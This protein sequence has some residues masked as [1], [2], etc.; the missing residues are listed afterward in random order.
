MN[1]PGFILAGGASSRYGSPKALAPVGGVRVVDRVA[2][3]LRA[4]LHGAAAGAAEVYAIVN[5]ADLAVE[6]GLPHRADVIRGVGP[7]AGIHAALHWARELGGVG[8]LAAGCDMPF[9]EPALLG[10]LVGRSV[11]RDVVIP[12]SDGPR[13]VEPLC[14]FYGT[15][16][17]PAIEAA[18]ER[19]DA[20]MIGFHA[21]LRVEVLPLEVVRTFGD[22]A[23][24]F[25]NVNTVDD[26][27]AADRLEAP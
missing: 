18:I 7:L 21:S 3:A 14:A 11:D 8:G 19:G 9:L 17:L 22:P 23:R 12:A 2:A 27:A 1:V 6:I 24:M 10:E 20:R 26:R 4:A 16:C 15:G 13:G 5:D 25:L